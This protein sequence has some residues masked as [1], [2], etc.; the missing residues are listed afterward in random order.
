MSMQQVSPAVTP[1]PTAASNYHAPRALQYERTDG[2]VGRAIYSAS[3]ALE[4]IEVLAEVL[5]CAEMEAE[6]DEPQ[7][8]LSIRQRVAFLQGA[9]L[10]AGLARHELT[11]AIEGE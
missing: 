11:S 4:S 5:K 3:L 6:F 1:Q 7:L 8:V 10:L 9:G 2:Q